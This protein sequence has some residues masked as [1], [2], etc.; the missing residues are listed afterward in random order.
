ML[1][2][3]VYRDDSGKIISDDSIFTHDISVGGLRLCCP[4]PL[5]KGKVLDLKIFLFN[6]P[7]HLPARGRVVWSNRKKS[8]E[9]AVSSKK[10]DSEDEVYWAG[11]QFIDID[12][13]TR[14]RILSWIRKE[15]DVV[16]G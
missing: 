13:F 15:F 4:S 8:L 2:A 11:V 3:T 5:T 7:I 14:E 6:D 1:I 9:V 16:E 12:A 10:S